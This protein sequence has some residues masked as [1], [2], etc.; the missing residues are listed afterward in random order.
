MNERSWSQAQ[1]LEDNFINLPF[2]GRYKEAEIFVKNFM[3]AVTVTYL[4][5][6]GISLLYHVISNSS[7]VS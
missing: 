1:D 4:L 5:C 2:G 6:S 7:N 3:H